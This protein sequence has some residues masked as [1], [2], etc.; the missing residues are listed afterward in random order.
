[1]IDQLTEEIDRSLLTFMDS[2]PANEKRIYK[3][4][5]LELRDLTTYSDGKIK[6]NLQNIKK[7]ASIRKQLDDIILNK[8]YLTAVTGFAETYTSVEKIQNLYF[9]KLVSDYSPMAVLKEVKKQAVEQT[10]DQLTEN[11][12]ARALKDDVTE[13]LKVNITSGGSYADLTEQLR[14]K[15][16]GNEEVEGFMTRYAGQITTDAVNG[17]S[18]TYTKL[19]TDDLGLTWLRFVGSLIKTSRP[20]CK[21]MVAFSY[22]HI[23]QFPTLIK[24]I[25]DGKQTPLGKNGLPLGFNEN[26][27]VSNYQVLRNGYFC[28]HQFVPISEESVPKSIRIK[29]YTELGIEFNSDGFAI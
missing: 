12:M 28:G 18:A 6:N 27:T 3:E 5:L 15:I 4:L 9:S 26:T 2:L 20:Q 16:V 10:V 11:G 8:D 19:I 14:D 7:I 1:M 24:G 25:V 23:K 13:I 22:F 21:A 29:I 17:F